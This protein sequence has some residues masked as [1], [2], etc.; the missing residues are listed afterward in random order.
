[1]SSQNFIFLSAGVPEKIMDDGK[2]DTSSFAQ[3]AEPM[4]IGEAIL[5]LV[6]VCREFDLGIVFGGHPAISPLVHHAGERLGILSSIH[7]YQSEYFLNRHDIVPPAAWLFPN[8]HRAAEGN[9]FDESCKILRE[10][11]IASRKWDF[12]AGVFVGGKNGVAIEFNLFG[13]A[14]TDKP[15]YPL[16]SPGGAARELFNTLAPAARAP[17]EDD[18]LPVPGRPP[19]KQ[20]FRRVLLA[21][22]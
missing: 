21:S 18:A 1:M 15:R 5:A 6:T 14:Y 3:T 17:I 8:L 11:M 2:P 13:G 12:R 9:D 7:I 22:K 10:K 20:L 4:L 16:Y 19:Y